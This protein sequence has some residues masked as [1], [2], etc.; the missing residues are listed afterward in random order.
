MA[1]N[2]SVSALLKPKANVSRNVFPLDQKHVFSMKAGQI[3]PVKALHFMPNDFFKIQ[4]HD[5]T[6]SFP[7]NTA[8]FLR[9]RKETSFYSVYYSAV[10]SLFN[11]YMATRSDPKTSALLKI[12]NAIKE[13]RI[14]LWEMYSQVWFQF[15][16]YIVLNYFVKALAIKKYHNVLHSDGYRREIELVRAELLAYEF[17][18]SN[19]TNF[20]F[21]GDTY[22]LDVFLTSRISG[23]YLKQ[24]RIPRFFLNSDDGPDTVIRDVVFDIVGQYRYSNYLRKLDMLGYGNIYP[25]IERVE[26]SCA[27]AYASLSDDEA[28]YQELPS[29]FIQRIQKDF[30]VAY[31][32]CFL[33]S[34]TA[35]YTD[36]IGWNFSDANSKKVNLY[37]ICAY[38]AVF[39]HFFRNSFYDLDYSPTN[40]NL[41][42]RYTIN[43]SSGTGVFQM[44][45]FTRRFLDLEYHQWKKDLFTSVLPDTQFG[46]VSSLSIN[47]DPQNSLAGAV[48]YGVTGNAAG[49]WSNS[50]DEDLDH[51]ELVLPNLQ[52]SQNDGPLRIITHTHDY[53]GSIDWSAAS[54]NVANAID[55]IAIKR[56][57]ML[58]D[59]RQTL[60]RA[61]NKTSD[62]FKA[63]YGGAPSSEHEDDIIPRFLE[64]FGEDIF[65]DPVEA[66]ATTGNE[67][68]GQLGDLSARAKLRGDSK[69]FKFNAGS[70]FG[71][72]LCLSYIVPE[73]EYNSYILDKHNLEL[74]PEAHFLPTYENWGL[75]PI[76]SDELNALLPASD[77]KALGF[78]PRYY[79]KKQAI[80]LV[81]GAFVSSAISFAGDDD[82]DY[83][84]D[85]FGE[86]NHWVVPRTDL[87]NRNVTL[88]RD[89]YINPR[90]LD[91]VFVRAAGAD[92]A[93]DQ[94]ICNTY[95]EITSTRGMSKV[96]LINFV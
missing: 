44:F 66:T 16:W 71:V 84:D 30:A 65:V 11:Q 48:P 20:V 53:S 3:T 45:E 62:I 27:L 70:N 68:N 40:Y 2:A 38:N 74:S 26:R 73:A 25:F 94:F 51:I 64:T 95:L 42:F 57:E 60:M 10:W 81:H 69:T 92:L 75:E 34:T 85:F 24:R 90:I 23:Q 43:Y 46:A 67:S 83:R 61:G 15:Y 82:D 6:L 7:M 87:Q 76:Y 18:P 59:Y 47:I 21:E 32:E 91:N 50:A 49:R 89:F 93:D 96:G 77:I 56:A 13:P 35:T 33:S 17:L 80:D 4:A 5:F 29:L 8:A 88:K 79:H 31:L 78:A 52:G 12:S 72:I 22:D 28:V 39:Y 19:P 1:K 9:G 63:I 14:R 58:Q 55:V 36:G 41:D 86:F 37:A 54:G